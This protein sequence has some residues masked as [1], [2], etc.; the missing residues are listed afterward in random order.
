MF[1]Q[2]DQVPD[3]FLAGSIRDSRK[4]PIPA[5]K[6]LKERNN[7]SPVLTGGIHQGNNTVTSGFPPKLFPLTRIRLMS[8]DVCS[9]DVHTDV[10]SGKKTCQV[11]L[12]FFDGKTLIYQEFG[13]SR[14]K[15]N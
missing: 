11:V 12:S 5:K 3:H 14:N 7:I 13:K 6:W 4:L 1:V 9:F 15:W 10:L 8:V 2:W